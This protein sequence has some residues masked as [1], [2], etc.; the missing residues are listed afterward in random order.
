MLR[1]IRRTLARSAAALSLVAAALF[2]STSPASAHTLDEAVRAS[3]GCAWLSGSYNNLHSSP[4][5]TSGGTTYGT[6]HLLWSSTYRQNC[7]VTLKTGSTHGVATTTRAELFLQSGGSYWEQG[8]FAHYAAA[9]AATAGVCVAYQGRI[10]GTSGTWA[11]GGRS[12]WDN[13]S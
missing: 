2:V 4:V 13:C 8:D 6:V 5:R 10:Q 7:V 3:A 1:G 11:T 12:T 9:S